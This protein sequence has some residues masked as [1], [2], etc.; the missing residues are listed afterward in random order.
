MSPVVR[1]LG[2]YRTV[3]LAALLAAAVPAGLQ[4]QSPADSVTQAG[5]VRASA[6]VDAVFVDKQLAEGMV[7]AGDWASYLMAR[8]GIVPIP[9]DLR[10]RVASDS[11]RVVISSRLVDLPPE[12]R[13]A[14]GPLVG[15]L[16]PTTEI[17]GDITL[18]QPAREVVQFYLDRVRVN[19]APLPEGIVAAVMADV[20]RQ[21]PALSRS[22][23]SLYV[24]VPADAQVQF[25]PGWVRLIGPPRDTIGRAGR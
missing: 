24:Q 7:G 23:R 18:Q 11:T 16:P 5:V 8:L 13:A 4:A 2:K 22:G 12:A 25:L 10:V 14:L 15:M 17:A 20:G 21:Y 3:L 9:P 6:Y 1:R 19:G